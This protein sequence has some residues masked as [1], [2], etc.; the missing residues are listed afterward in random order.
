MSAISLT[1]NPPCCDH[2]DRVAP[3]WIKG[4]AISD[5]RLALERF[6]RIE[7][8][9]GPIP[10]RTPTVKAID[11]DALGALVLCTFQVTYPRPHSGNEVANSFPTRARCGACRSRS[12]SCYT[13]AARKRLRTYAE[14]WRGS[15]LLSGRS[16]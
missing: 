6:W 15:S 13:Y 12:Y 1:R 9:E 14:Q 11:R 7:R 8:P 2:L 5:V 16:A 10:N 4:K 3:L